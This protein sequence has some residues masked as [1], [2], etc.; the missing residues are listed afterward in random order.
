MAVSRKA[1]GSQKAREPVDVNE[2]INKGGSVA[3]SGKSKTSSGREIQAVNLKI[4]KDVLAQ[5][6]ELVEQ[7][8][9][10]TPRHTWLMEAVF[11]K[12]NR[13]QSEQSS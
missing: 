3:K 1:T 13:E 12:L 4:P 11:E 9:I 7:R 5:I 10:H 6:D 2:L 8:P